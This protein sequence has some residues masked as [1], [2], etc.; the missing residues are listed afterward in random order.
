MHEE[1]YEPSP[2]REALKRYEE[3]FGERPPLLF[4]LGRFDADLRRL[5]DAEM[6]DERREIRT[7]W[8]TVAVALLFIVALSLALLG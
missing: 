4:W 1:P 5:V 8:L 7:L 2:L 3:A 6:M